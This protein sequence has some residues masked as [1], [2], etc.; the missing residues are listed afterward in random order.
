MTCKDR[1]E[2]KEEFGKKSIK[3]VTFQKCAFLELVENF[4]GDDLSREL[5]QKF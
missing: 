2:N 4:P 3:E 1:K 5:N